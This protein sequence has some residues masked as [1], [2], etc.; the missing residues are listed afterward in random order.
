[1]C[2]E[3]LADILD[4]ISSKVTKKLKYWQIS[5]SVLK[6]NPIIKTQHRFHEN[7]SCDTALSNLVDQIESGILRNQLVLVPNI[8]IA[9][10]F[11]SLSYES[12]IKAIMER[13]IPEKNN[14]VVQTFPG[15]SSRLY[16]NK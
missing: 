3:F 12:A 8:D 11:D 15:M 16:S 5:D 9:S 6:T 14:T 4:V 2:E 10:A 1:M 7:Y 13:K